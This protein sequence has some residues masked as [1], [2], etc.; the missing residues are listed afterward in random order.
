[1]ILVILGT[2]DKTFPRLLDA[3]QKQ[4][5][6]GNISK[7]EKIIVQS[8]STQYNSK[9][10]KILDYI[11]IEEFDKLIEEADLIISHAGVGT[12]ITALNKGKKVIAA[13]RLQKYGEHV[14]D[15]QKQIL[16]NFKNEGYILALEEFD[17]LNDLIEQSKEF[18]PK[19]L[20]SN[21]EYFLSRLE[22]EIDKDL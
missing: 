4:I 17:K 22:N 15:H 12:I 1:M 19:K 10:M 8:G 13:A 6:I 20:K 5:D 2:Q 21:K 11:D 9:D 16:E 18:I 3:V 7:K 14:N